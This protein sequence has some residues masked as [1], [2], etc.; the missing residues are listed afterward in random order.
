MTVKNTAMVYHSEYKKGHTVSSISCKTISPS[1]VLNSLVKF[2]HPKGDCP[3]SAYKLSVSP[4]KTSDAHALSRFY[5]F[6]P[7]KAGD[8][9]TETRMSV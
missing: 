5:L 1:V 6:Y 8:C 4:T 9:G 2:S 7:L 3:V